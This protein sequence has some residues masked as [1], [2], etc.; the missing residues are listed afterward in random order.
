MNDEAVRVSRTVEVAAWLGV[1]AVLL[2]HALVSFEHIEQ[3]LLYQTLNIAGSIAM[4]VV[5]FQKHA[6]P[7]FAINVLWIGIAVMALLQ[8]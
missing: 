8:P 3:G 7:P 2:A 6:W 1:A 5:C 4:A